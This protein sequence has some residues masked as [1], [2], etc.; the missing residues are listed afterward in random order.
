[1]ATPRAIRGV[2]GN[3]LGTY[4]SRN[5]DFDGYWLFGFLVSELGELRIDLLAPNAGEPN[6]PLGA[7]VQLAAAQ[8]DDQMRKAGLVRSQVREAWLTIRKLSGSVGGSIGGHACAGNNLSISAWALMDG[9]RRY[10]QEKIMFVAPHNAKIE[11]RS[12]RRA[13]QKRC[14]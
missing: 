11:L 14:I 13:E 6:S 12:A 2:L 5:T 4:T 7:A 3:F 8:F 9:G 1:M 10:E